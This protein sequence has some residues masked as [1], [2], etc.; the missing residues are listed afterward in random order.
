MAYSSVNFTFT[1]TSHMLYA[2]CKSHQMPNYHYSPSSAQISINPRSAVSPK[3]CLLLQHFNT[4][5][6]KSPRK[7]TTA[8]RVQNT[9]LTTYQSHDGPPYYPRATPRTPSLLLK[10]SVNIIHHSVAISF[11]YTVLHTR[12]QPLLQPR[13][14][15]HK[16]HK[17]Q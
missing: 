2:L 7:Y 13:R 15:P 8:A 11:C 10:P 3:H 16:S 5:S 6:A 1:F 4:P 17:E 14:V 9:R 12:C